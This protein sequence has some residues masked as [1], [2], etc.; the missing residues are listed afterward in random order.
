MASHPP[1]RPTRWLALGF[2]LVV[3]CSC[4]PD[5]RPGSQGVSEAAEADLPSGPPPAAPDGMRLPGGV[6]PSAYRLELTI[7]PSEDRFYG[8]AAI[9]V[10]SDAARRAI[11]LHGRGLHVTSAVVR[12][13]DGSTRAARY[14]EVRGDGVAVVYTRDELPAG[15][16]EILLEYDAPFGAAL[17]GLY[18]V[19]DGGGEYAFTQFE[20][21]AARQAFP[22]FDEPAYKATFELALRV[23]DGAVAVA[24]GLEDTRQ[25][26]ETGEL[27]RFRPTPPISTYLLAFAVGPFDV[28]DAGELPPNEVRTTPL[29]LRGVAARGRGRQLGPALAKVEPVLRALER[30]FGTPYPYEKL[31]LLA[32]PDFA[33]GAMENVGLV[34]FREP[35]LLLAEPAPDWQ[36]RAVVYVMA[37][38]LAHMWFGNLVTMEFWDDLWLNEAFAT[39]MSYR[40]ALESHPEMR[41][42]LAEVQSIHSA[43]AA[44]S[45]VS[46]R[47][48]RQ[49]IE[50]EH[51]IRNAFDAITYRKGAGVLRMFERFIGE[52]TFRNGVRAYLAAHREGTATAAD[53]VGALEEASGQALAAP[54]ASFLDQAGLPLVEATV[55]CAPP[56]DP[57]ASATV[58]LRQTRYLPLGAEAPGEA[59]RWQ[60]P[61]C[62]RYGA[63]GAAREA[64]GMLDAETATLALPGAA[65]PSF[66]LPNAG[67]GG[68]FRFALDASAIDGLS[69]WGIR[70]L[71][72]EERLAAIDSIVAGY[73]QGRVPFRTLYAYLRVQTQ[74]QERTLATAPMAPLA[75][76]V[77]RVVDDAAR[78]KARSSV[79]QLYQS[80][81]RTL[82]FGPRPN[83]VE[84]A[85]TRML[86]ADVLGFLALVGRDTTVRSQLLRRARAFLGV[87]VDHQVHPEA[88]DPG[89]VGPAL[90]VAAQDGGRAMFDA[91]ELTLVSTGDALLRSHL[92]RALG[93]VTDPELAERARALALDRRLRLN[94]ATLPL[95]AQMEQPETREA[96]FQY[97]TTH[98]DELVARLGTGRSSYLLR[99]GAAFC[100]EG[101][102]E[103][104]R[105]ALAPKAS[106][107]TGGPRELDATLETVRLCA[108][109]VAAQRAD[110]SG[111]FVGGR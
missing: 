34:T 96:A 78:A 55:A 10:T 6:R 13:P 92:L 50:S 57:A 74:S 31:D 24:S 26:E 20:P 51:D 7:D 32:V 95:F 18:K 3:G 71:T 14:A 64:C 103:R 52:E 67:A 56:G 4:G 29:R 17:Q 83:R 53:L 61:I 42:S 79:R 93:S 88:I 1:R 70:F 66:V 109:R 43:M 76:V 39:F 2:V 101:D 12:L 85:E 84:D 30:W 94:E 22:C 110:A 11:F 69:R 36:E 104:V 23:P 75:F 90:V 44:D 98:W 63:Q 9:A 82:G 45:L 27:V 89:L 108:A 81:V 47:R 72:P 38:E 60:V 107:L 102:V 37:H 77:E 106:R 21:T 91:M 62:V 73:D 49:P 54:F 16:L 40:A 59:P 8:R 15:P 48:V 35:L 68:Y 87:G 58:T 41:P 25:S 5:A 19:R 99:L 105:E 100:G 28:V 46:A 111:F 86:R 33:A 65:C 97:A 80:R